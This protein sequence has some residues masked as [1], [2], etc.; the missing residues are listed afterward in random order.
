[1][2]LWRYVKRGASGLRGARVAVDTPHFHNF[3]SESPW[4]RYCKQRTITTQKKAWLGLDGQ[5]PPRVPPPD[6]LGGI[7]LPP[8]PAGHRRSPPRKKP[9]DMNR[10]VLTCK[11]L[12]ADAP[13]ALQ[14][15][16]RGRRLQDEVHRDDVGAGRRG[17]PRRAGLRAH[18]ARQ[19][20]EDRGRGYGFHSFGSNLG[21]I[22]FVCPR[23]FMFVGSYLVVINHILHSLL[24]L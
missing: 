10:L 7:R 13:R 4:I 9:G 20:H 12:H 1:M 15:P 3:S 6:R 23:G 17:G 2:V 18:Q 16:H 8:R 22:F 24:V 11:V 5:N 19:L 21:R 14:V